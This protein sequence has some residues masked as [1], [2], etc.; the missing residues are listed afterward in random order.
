MESKRKNILI[1]GA[2]S[3]LGKG[4]ALEYARQ[5]CNLALAARRLER[6]EELKAELLNINP[7]IK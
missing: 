5:G 1:T 4:M 3:G 2:S 6:L 7:A